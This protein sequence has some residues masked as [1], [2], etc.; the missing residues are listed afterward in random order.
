MN[1]NMCTQV[2]TSIGWLGRDIW[3]GEREKIDEE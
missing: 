2:P 3:E 1:I